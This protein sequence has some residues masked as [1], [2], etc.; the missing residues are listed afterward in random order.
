[1]DAPASDETGGVYKFRPHI[2][3]V[4]SLQY[5]PHDPAQLISAS[6]DG[7]LRCLD[8]TKQV[9]EKSCRRGRRALGVPH[10]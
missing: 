7:T 4:A 3:K 6:H 9:S 10:E 5:H 2:S 8:L 1:M